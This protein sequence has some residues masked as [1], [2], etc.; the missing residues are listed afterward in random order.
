MAWHGWFVAKLEVPLAAKEH[1]P[2]ILSCDGTAKVVGPRKVGH[3]AA[4]E[5]Q[6]RMVDPSQRPDEQIDSAGT[7]AVALTALLDRGTR[8]SY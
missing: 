6:D 4:K 8:C 7:S 3:L 2:R 1:W 5:V